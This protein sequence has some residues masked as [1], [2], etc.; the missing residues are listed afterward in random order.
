MGVAALTTSP[1]VAKHVAIQGAN[2]CNLGTLVVLWTRRPDTS[3]LDLL[4]LTDY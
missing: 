4:N 3:D 1:T 2:A